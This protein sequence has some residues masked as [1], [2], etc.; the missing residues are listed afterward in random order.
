MKDE[1]RES[2]QDAV[3]TTF[4]KALRFGKRVLPLSVGSWL[5][6]L[7]SDRPAIGRVRFGD[8]ARASP[9]DGEFGFGRGTPIDRFY[10]ESFLE[11]N[12]HDIAGRVLEIG[13]PIYSR[14]FG[15]ERVTWQDV[16]DV[17]PDNLQATII[18]DI[19][20]PDVL[21]RDSFDCIVLTQTL[22]YI[23]D[24]R[25]AVAELHAAL[26]P[27]GVLLITLPGIS[28]IEPHFSDG[29]RYWAFTPASASRLFVEVFGAASVSVESHGNVF[30]AVSFLHGVA[31]EEVPASKILVRDADYPMIVTLRAVR[32]LQG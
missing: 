3:E 26:K 27:G 15:A 25:A 7:G 12:R 16:L 4:Q 6:P 10:I 23:Y 20:A 9:I 32:R 24:L 22:Q 11:R 30:A 21:P 1:S 2:A 29:T 18:G 31:L 17:R 19:S 14:R 28:Q 13:N 5:D 8:L